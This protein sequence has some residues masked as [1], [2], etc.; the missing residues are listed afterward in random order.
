MR[1][2]SL[3]F[4]PLCPRSGH[5]VLLEMEMNTFS[6]SFCLY[7]CE[8]KWQKG[9]LPR[10]DHWRPGT[11]TGCCQQPVSWRLSQAHLCAV[12]VVCSCCVLAAFRVRSCHFCQPK[13]AVTGESPAVPEVQ[14]MKN[15][16]SPIRGGRVGKVLINFS[17]GALGKVSFLFYLPVC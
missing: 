9:F 1:L 3:S 8:T 14:K 4:L 15:T 17:S 16:P 5:K 10:L 11:H 7:Q 2:Q 12:L 6:T 13:P